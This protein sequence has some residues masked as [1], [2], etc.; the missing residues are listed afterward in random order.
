MKFNTYPKKCKMFKLFKNFKFHSMSEDRW[1]TSSTVF[2]LQTISDQPREMC[3]G[4]QHF[5]TSH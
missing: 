1:A 4:S 3:I 5:C 2:G